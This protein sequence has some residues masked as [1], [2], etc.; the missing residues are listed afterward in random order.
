MKFPTLSR[1]KLPNGGDLQMD[2]DS[3]RARGTA[4]RMGMLDRMTEQLRGPGI[5]LK[6]AVGIGRDE[7]WLRAI[8]ACTTDPNVRDVGWMGFSVSPIHPNSRQQLIDVVAV[9]L[10]ADPRTLRIVYR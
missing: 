10:R 2:Q 1:G 6:I 3:N 8:V 7:G 9:G 5:G 4:E